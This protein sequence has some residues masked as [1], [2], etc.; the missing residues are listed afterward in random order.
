[1]KKNAFPTQRFYLLVVV[2]LLLS[3]ILAA[4]GGGATEA[5][6]APASDSS[7]EATEPAVEATQPPEE[8]TEPPAEEPA[9]TEPPA[10]DGAGSEAP[11]GA[12]SF[13]NDIQ[14]I[15]NASCSSCHGSR[16]SGGVQLDSFESLMA[17]NVITAG[18]AAGSILWQEV[19]SGSMP[20]AGGK[21]SA[22]QIQLIAD[23]INAGANND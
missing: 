20:K 17:S 12:P 10:D 13:A 6:E 11:A 1:M 2:T 22:E 18:D 8:A 21:L 3:L 9:A 16:A 23:W 15:F 19:E 4:C 5:T 14:P 7:S